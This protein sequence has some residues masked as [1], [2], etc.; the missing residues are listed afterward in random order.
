MIVVKRRKHCGAGNIDDF[1]SVLTTLRCGLS[2]TRCQDKPAQE[3]FSKTYPWN[4]VRSEWTGS[5][6]SRPLDTRMKDDSVVLSWVSRSFSRAS[7]RTLKR[8]SRPHDVPS[9]ALN[10]DPAR[11]RGS[12]TTVDTSTSGL[13]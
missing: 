1:N 3:V 13:S 6:P 11:A 10:H 12:W 7:S 9:V 5:A 2:V 8:C 4:P